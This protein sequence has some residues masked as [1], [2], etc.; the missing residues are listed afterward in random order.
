[1]KNSKKVKIIIEPSGETFD[2]VEFIE[3]VLD[4]KENKKEK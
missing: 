1:M 4:F 2:M 3:M